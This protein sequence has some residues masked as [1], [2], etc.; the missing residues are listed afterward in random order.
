VQSCTCV[1][2]WVRYLLH[3]MIN[4]SIISCSPT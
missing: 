2:E 3:M 4:C 1:Y